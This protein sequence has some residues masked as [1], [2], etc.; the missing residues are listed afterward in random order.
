MEFINPIMLS[1]SRTRIGMRGRTF[2]CVA[3]VVGALVLSSPD[4][5]GQPRLAAGITGD[6]RWEESIAAFA[7]ADRDHAPPPGGVVFVGS[8]SIRLWDD[9]ENQFNTGRRIIKRG[10]G[11]ANMSDCTRYLDRIVLPYKPRLVLVYA[12]DNDL[13]EG[14]QPHDVFHDFERFVERL[15]RALPMARIGFISIKP[16]PARAMLIPKIR[17]A[18]D[19]ILRFTATR[20][21]VD[22]IDVFTPMLDSA[23]H[24][25]REL[26]LTDALHLNRAGYKLW[27]TIIARYV[28]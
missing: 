21:H 11:G 8:S 12:G 17:E 2:S 19:L 10:F 6:S 18:N 4:A 5:R 28:R 23:G 14:K 16:S 1:H 26:F 13:A 24:P 3:I 25:R 7:V 20:D 27:K 15:H 22:F 9:L